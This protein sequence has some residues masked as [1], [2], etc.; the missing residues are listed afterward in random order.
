MINELDKNGF[1]VARNFFSQETVALLQQYFHLKFIKLQCNKEYRDKVRTVVTKDVADSYSFYSDNFTDSLMIEYGKRIEGIAQS[2]LLPTYT[3]ARVYEKGSYLR[4]HVDRPSCEISATCPIL[5]SDFTS[6]TIYVANYDFTG[7]DFP[8]LEDV[9]ARGDYTRV[10][11]LP[12][13]IMLYK[14]VQRLH[15]REPLQSDTLIQFFMHYV[16]AD[17][18]YK[19]FAFDKKPFVGWI[20]DSTITD[21]EVLDL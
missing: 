5:N 7:Q 13:D 17:G 21:L 9:K 15:W 8:T 2:S 18:K 10:D 19:E 1:T 6:S 11:L 4:P 12:G 20:P 14:G 3:Y 16:R